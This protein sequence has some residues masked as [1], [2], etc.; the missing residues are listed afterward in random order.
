LVEDGVD[1]Q[2]S[3]ACK[4]DGSLAG[5]IPGAV[6]GRLNGKR[7]SL[8]VQIPGFLLDGAENQLSLS[9]IASLPIRSKQFPE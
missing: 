5:G 7:L 2:F 6:F 4:R 8:Q 1:A 9:F 3:A